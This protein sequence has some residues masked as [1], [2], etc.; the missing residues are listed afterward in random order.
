MSSNEEDDTEID[1]PDWGNFNLDASP[2]DFVMTDDNLA[3][4]VLCTVQDIITEA[5][6][7]GDDESEGCDGCN[8][9]GLGDDRSDRHSTTTGDTLEALDTLRG[10]VASGDLSDQ[11]VASFYDFRK[12]LLL[13]IKKKK[14]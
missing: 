12:S 5:M 3:T 4:C 10:F 14:V 13:D 2:K 9:Q 11:T 6:A 7:E 8:N 1:I